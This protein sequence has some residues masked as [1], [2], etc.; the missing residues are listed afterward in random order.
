MRDQFQKNVVPISLSGNMTWENRIQVEKRQS[1]P[2]KCL[3]C[4]IFIKLHLQRVL[5]NEDGNNCS[6]TASK[7]ALLCVLFDC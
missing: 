2:L 6:I 3:Q 1:Y 5:S 4:Y 7:T